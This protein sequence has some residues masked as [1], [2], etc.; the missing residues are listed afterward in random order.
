MTI[1]RVLV[2]AVGIYGAVS[3]ADIPCSTVQ[4]AEGAIGAGDSATPAP[5][6]QISPAPQKT[7]AAVV[8][9]K[10]KKKKAPAR[11]K[12]LRKAPPE[13]GGTASGKRLSGVEV[14]AILRTSRD[15][16]GKNLSGLNLVGVNLSKCNLR[17]V[18][19]RNANLERADLGESDLERANLA[20][21]NLRMASLK[22]SG[23]IGA[24]LENAILDGAIWQDGRICAKGSLGVCREA[25]SSYSAK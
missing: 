3:L 11:G 24:N 20:G 5:A 23:M 19:L 6:D 17:G 9:K 1:F 25:F 13:A 22:L 21:A 4:A 2:V 7:V 10:R 12:A 18:D 16:S 14:M 15:L 8:P